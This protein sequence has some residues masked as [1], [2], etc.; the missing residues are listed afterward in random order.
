MTFSKVTQI[1]KHHTRTLVPYDVVGENSKLE[2]GHKCVKNF[3]LV[4]SPVVRVPLLIV[5]A[6]KQQNVRPVQIE[7]ISS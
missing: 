2:V 5:N 4:T 1:L 6:T 7:R 3:L